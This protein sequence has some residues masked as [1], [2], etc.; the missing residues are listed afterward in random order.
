VRR[1][2]GPKPP[3]ELGPRNTN[4]YWEYWATLDGQAWSPGFPCRTVA[5][6]EHADARHWRQANLWLAWPTDNQSKGSTSI[7]LCGSRYMG[8]IDQAG[9]EIKPAALKV[10]SDDSRARRL[11]RIPNE[12][13]DLRSIRDYTTA[14]HGKQAHILRGDLH[15]HTE[16]SWDGGGGCDGS[17]L[18]FY[19]YMIDA[20]AMDFGASTDI[21]AAVGYWWYYA[22]KMTDIFHV[23]GAYA[24]I[25]G[26]ERS[27]VLRTAT[28]TSCLRGDRN[29]AS[30][31]ST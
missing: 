27:A 31:P 14:V 30:F 26:F 10:T 3:P 29:H 4:G 18:D 17:L 5:A 11:W 19:R 6:F 12:A 1:I 21:R 7:G 2:L 8:Y 13:A 22:Q 20:A 23:P 28:A 24:P 16:F 25:F 9:I 15:R